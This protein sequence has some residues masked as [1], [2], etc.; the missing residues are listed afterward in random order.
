MAVNML[1]GLLSTASILLLLYILA[2][3]SERFGAVVKMPPLYKY[4]YLALGLVI[5][6]LLT[7]FITVGAQLTLLPGF[8]WLK[9]P[10]FLL[11]LYHLPLGVS[12]TIALIVTWRYWSWLI[13]ERDG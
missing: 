11:I 5:I 7:Q 1:P 13:T 9:A 2:R 6:S 4:Y 8:D 12:M 10:W 3:L